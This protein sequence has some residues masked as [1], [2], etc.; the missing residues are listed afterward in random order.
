[1]SGPSHEAVSIFLQEA[2]EHLQY[3]REYSGILA[4]SGAPREDLERLHIAAHTLAGTSASFG[5]PRFAEIAGKLAHIFQYVL[6]APFNADLHGPLTEFISDGISVLESNLLEISDSGKEL[7]DDIQAFKE[8]YSFAFPAE[9]P[10]APPVAPQAPAEPDYAAEAAAT[11][12]SYFDALPADDEVPGEI[13]EFFMPEA[14]EHLQVVSDCLLTLEGSKDPEVI[15]KLFRSIHTV[16]GS[17]AQ[18][19]LKRLGAIAHRIEDL[20]GR[21]REGQLEPTPDVVDLCLDCMDV[22]KKC[23][24][25]QWKDDAELRVSVDSLLAR[26]A[27][28]APQEAEDGEAAPASTAPPPGEPGAE[29]PQH[30]ETAPAARQTPA[31]RPATLPCGPISANW[32]WTATTTSTFS[33]AP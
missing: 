1:M 3:L 15:H 23:V 11:T 18:V 24:H 20:I 14:E 30:I 8:R 29:E 10:P 5:F 25:R 6:N 31:P 32:K 16:K 19:G 27:E 13:L 12:G 4:E 26:I 7:G 21:M 33:P 22:L 9:A 17:A 28:Y 2:S